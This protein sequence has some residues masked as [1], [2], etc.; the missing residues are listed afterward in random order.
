MGG[1]IISSNFPSK[2]NSISYVYVFRLKER[3]EAP[4]GICDGPRG[5]GIVLNQKT[6]GQRPSSGVLRHRV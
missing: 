2:V 1:C 3:L 5:F 6:F 4:E